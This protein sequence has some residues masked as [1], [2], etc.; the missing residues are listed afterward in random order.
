[1]RGIEAAGDVLF[2]EQGSVAQTDAEK[3]REAGRRRAD[4]LALMA[5]RALGAGFGP[6]TDETNVPVSG[7]RAD[8]YPGRAPRRAHDA[9][10]GG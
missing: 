4:G 3:H 6:P 2:R 8:R 10:R 1:M 5:E 9:V 7:N